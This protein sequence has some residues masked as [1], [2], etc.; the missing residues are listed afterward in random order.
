MG[1]L[2]VMILGVFGVVAVISMVLLQVSLNSTED[3]IKKRSYRKTYV[4][5]I[6][7]SVLMILLDVSAIVFVDVYTQISK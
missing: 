5:I 2:D 3:V 1:Y 6:T 7:I 4:P